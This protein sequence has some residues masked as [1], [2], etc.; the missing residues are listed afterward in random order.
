LTALASSPYTSGDEVTALA[1]DTGK[2]YVI[3]ASAGGTPDLTMYAF[4]ALTA[5]QLDA[6]ATSANG[7]GTGSIAL[8]TTH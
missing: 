5:G 2:K 1:E 6:V 7:G 3:A 4:D 8:A